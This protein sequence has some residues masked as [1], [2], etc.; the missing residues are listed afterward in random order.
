MK[1]CR[2]PAPSTITPFGLP[3]RTCAT[4]FIVSARVAAPGLRMM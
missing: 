1:P 4:P 2:K 3:D